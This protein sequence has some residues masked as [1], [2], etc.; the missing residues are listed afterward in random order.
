MALVSLKAFWLARGA[1]YLSR[2]IRCSNPVRREPSMMSCCNLSSSM[3]A[4]SPEAV[5]RVS[6]KDS[7]SRLRQNCAAERSFNGISAFR[8]G[9]KATRCFL[10]FKVSVEDNKTHHSWLAFW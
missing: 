10:W 5:L 9:K 6:A 7:P 3:T 8:L 1:P 4:I 2:M